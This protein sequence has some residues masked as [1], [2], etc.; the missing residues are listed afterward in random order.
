MGTRW[1]G[2]FRRDA[3]TGTWTHHGV[4][5]GLVSGQINWLSAA[6]GGLWATT[7]FGVSRFDG[8]RWTTQ[9]L[10]TAVQAL[11]KWYKLVPGRDGAVW[12]NF[13][14]DRTF[15]RTVRYQP[16]RTP[17]ETEHHRAIDTVHRSGEHL[18]ALIN[19][20]LDISKIEA[21]RLQLNIESFDLNEMVEGIGRMFEP[22]CAEKDLAWHLEADLPE[23]QVRSDSVKLRQVLIN[24]L[25]NAV[26]FTEAGAVTL[27]VAARQDDVYAFEVVDTGPGIAP[28]KQQNVFEAF[29]QED[30]GVRQGGTGLGLAI[31]RA[32]VELLGGEIGLES[33]PGEGA[34]FFLSLTLPPGEEAG[35]AD[36]HD[37]ARVRRLQEG[38]A[39]Y[40]LIVDDVA[41]NREIMEGLLQP[42]GVE[43]QTA[44]SGEEALAQI[45]QRLPDIVLL[46][47]RMPG[48]SG[49][50]VLAQVIDQYG[51]HA[52]KIIA[53]TASVLDHERQGYLDQGFDDFLDKPLRTADVYA[54]LAAHL[55]VEFVYDEA[56]AAGE[57]VG[58]WRGAQ[59]SEDAYAQLE[60][61]VGMHSIT[62]LNNVLD[63]ISA[64]APELGTHLRQLAQSYNMKEIKA[65]FEELEKP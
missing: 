4:E 9:A 40:A 45:N 47:I 63:A 52:P 1:R 13:L 30:A 16:E 25:G 50:E 41:T 20:V 33:T 34:C 18:L 44:T 38:Q 32:Y 27:K 55:G 57:E 3:E 17:P 12:L 39:V 59:L 37:W 10:H 46:D 58:D 7:E 8:Q 31:T 14:V 35:E 26:K 6:D 53:V 21:G 15:G 43:T 54:C 36:A 28:E 19:E 51:E 49:Q 61:A 65:T 29:Q 5:D 11:R 2:L 62:R 42:L 23:G 64:E 48:L 60:E 56:E 24:L 22:R